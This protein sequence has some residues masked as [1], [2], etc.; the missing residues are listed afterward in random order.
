M[1][2]LVFTRSDQRVS[3]SV[4]NW[5]RTRGKNKWKRLASGN[6]W[7]KS[8]PADFSWQ[9]WT[10]SYVS[11]ICMIKSLLMRDLWE[12]Y[13]SFRTSHAGSGLIYYLG[14]ITWDANGGE[15]SDGP[16]LTLGVELR[17]V[18]FPRNAPLL[19]INGPSEPPPR[20]LE[21]DQ[22]SHS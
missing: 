8:M 7:E 20:R 19:I 18:I 15:L 17:R 3:G 21:Q 14:Y 2:G 11:L 22:N 1:L 6:Y 9:H 16:C 5:N 4:L 13:A 12:R 10:R